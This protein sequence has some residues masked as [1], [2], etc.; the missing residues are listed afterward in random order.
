MPHTQDQSSSLLVFAPPPQHQTLLEVIV[1][2]RIALPSEARRPTP[3]IRQQPLTSVLGV[4]AGEEVSAHLHTHTQSRFEACHPHAV[5]TNRTHM[6]EVG[7]HQSQA[8]IRRP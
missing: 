6:W 7:Q 1:P 5:P 3:H 4:P 2:Q 8:T